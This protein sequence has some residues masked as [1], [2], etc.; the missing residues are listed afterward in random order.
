[1]VE[2]MDSYKKILFQI[3][4]KTAKVGFGYNCQKTMTTLDKETLEELK[5]ILEELHKKSKNLDGV[6]FYSL[7]ERC[8]L[9]GAD[10]NLISSL[11]TVAEA[12]SGAET[13]QEIFNKIE[14]LPIP[15]VAAVHGVCLGGG[16]EL[17]LS[18]QF[19][20]GSDDKSTQFGLPEVKLGLIPGF[21]GTFRMP[22]RVGL[23]TA[24]DLILTGKTLDSRR[25]K[26]K[27]LIDE[28]YARE[29][30]LTMAEKFFKKSEE[31]HSLKE[32]LEAFAQDNYFTKKIIFQKA[33]ETVFKTTKGFYQAPLK[34][35]EVMETGI[36]KKRESYLALES[37]AFGELCMGDQSQNLQHLFF[38]MENSKKYTGPE[39]T[40]T[41][42]KLKRG[43][44]LGAGTM[45][46]GIAWLM[47]EAGMSPKMKDL[48]YDALELGLKQ[49]SSNFLRSLK[50]KKISKDDF[51]RKQRSITPQLDYAGFKNID[52][53]IEAVV[54]KM[55]I[56]KSVFAEL[57][58]QVR[59]DTIITSNTSSLSVEEMATALE[60]PERFAGLHF[61]NPVH[62]MPLVEI[63]TH[64]KASPETLQGLYQ[65][66]VKTKKTPI[67]VKDG[68]GF[69]V[70]RILMPYLNE[71]GMLLEEGVSL[72]DIDN[73]A[74]NF[75]MPMGPFR[76]LD[77]VGIDVG[78]KVAQILHE[79]LGERCLPST[80]IKNVFEKGFLGK[81][82]KK[83]FYLYDENDREMGENEEISSLLPKKKNNMEETQIQMRLFLPMINESAYILK[84]KIVEKAQDVDLGLIFGIGFPPFRGGLLR[85]ADTEGLDNIVSAIEKFSQ[86][87]SETRF[88]LAPLLKEMIESK[89]KFY[90]L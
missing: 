43:A 32:S 25:A 3:D 57:E 41:P 85:Y 56:K 31:K 13:G 50:R 68:A 46:G 80:V 58:K 89:K 73:A 53:I 64:S 39:S 29:R 11:K 2:V 66:V 10:I 44:V 72:K 78:T 18:C 74:L 9:A 59:E 52:L 55:E 83:G 69:L 30:L 5:L 35:L 26:K 65:W 17:S 60:H 28:V 37:Q 87:V 48:N 40:K 16:M 12:S 49:A 36:S 33:R 23:P 70:N 45:G 86:D 84:E 6:I 19:I 22:K 27:G 62:R 79:G 77:E 47:A 21:G 71:A 67:V 7:K 8:F 42:L 38:M 51:E 75:G 14:D 54:E 20:L 76:L 34:I 15:T 81:K 82:N 61:F 4:G 1:M 24:L 88:K 63:I 90:D